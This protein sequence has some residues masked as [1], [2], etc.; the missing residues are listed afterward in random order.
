M[1]YIIQWTWS[2]GSLLFNCFIISFKV[3]LSTSDNLC[4]EPISVPIVSSKEIKGTN[5]DSYFVHFVVVRFPAPSKAFF[6]PNISL[7]NVLLPTPLFPIIIKFIFSN[8]FSLKD[9]FII[10]INCSFIFFM[11]FSEIK[12]L[13][14]KSANLFFKLV[15]L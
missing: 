3:S 12:S 13:S 4:P 2:L 10:L 7:I 9:V 1:Q 11:I 14:N 8:S 15:N 6:S 5:L